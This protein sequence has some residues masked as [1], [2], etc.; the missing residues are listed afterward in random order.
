MSQLK[1]AQ[2]ASNYD[3]VT[4]QSQTL[5]QPWHREEETQ[6]TNSLILFAVNIAVLY[7]VMFK[8]IKKL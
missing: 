4:P 5:D 3:Q 1:C 2:K 6:N 7:L 8:D